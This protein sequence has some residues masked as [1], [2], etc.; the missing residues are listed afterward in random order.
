MSI[1]RPEC[2]VCHRPVQVEVVNFHDRKVQR[3][4]FQCGAVYDLGTAS[5]PNACPVAMSA[6]LAAEREIASLRVELRNALEGAT[7]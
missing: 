2:P 5:W 6:Y 1:D 4:V 3:Q 7:A